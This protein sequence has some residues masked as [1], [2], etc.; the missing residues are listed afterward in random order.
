MKRKRHWQGFSL[1][2][3]ITTAIIVDGIIIAAMFVVF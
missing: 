1:L 3:L 2:E